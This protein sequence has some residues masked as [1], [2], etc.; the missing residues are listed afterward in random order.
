MNNGDNNFYTNDNF[1]S[2]DGNPIS[3]AQNSVQKTETDKLSLRCMVF[4]IISIA[5][6]FTCPC[7]PT[8]VFAIISL[9]YYFKA[10]KLLMTPKLGGNL[11]AGLIC[12]IIS[13]VYSVF[14]FLIFMFYIFIFVVVGVFAA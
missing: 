11:I 3:D 9:Y 12:S 10:K 6:T 7:L 13:L 1:Y 5:L 8:F 14:Y 2:N 4:G